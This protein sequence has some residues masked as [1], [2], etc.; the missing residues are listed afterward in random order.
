MWWNSKFGELF[1]KNRI[2]AT[3]HFFAINTF[4]FRMLEKKLHPKLNAAQGVKWQLWVQVSYEFFQQMYT[5]LLKEF[6]CFSKKLT[7]L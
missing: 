3:E 5:F 2:I 6:V 1:Q 7:I 4:V